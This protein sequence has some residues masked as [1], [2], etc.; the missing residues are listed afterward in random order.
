MGGTNNPQEYLDRYANE[1]EL[2]ID[3][4]KK[5]YADAATDGVINADQKKA[6]EL[7][8]TGTPFFLINRQKVGGLGPTVD[9]I[10]SEIDKA[11]KNSDKN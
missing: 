4:F 2:D 7:G 5:D 8:L 3:K 11:I 1:S 9:S 6:K 10:S